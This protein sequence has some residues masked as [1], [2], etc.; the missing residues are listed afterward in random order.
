MCIRDRPMA[1][2][3]RQVQPSLMLSAVR[4]PLS[5]TRFTAFSMASASAAM[6]TE[7]R[8]IMAADRIQAVGFTMSLPAISGAEP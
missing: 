4:R 6:P 3:P 1:V 2:Q 7:Y 8:S 5:S